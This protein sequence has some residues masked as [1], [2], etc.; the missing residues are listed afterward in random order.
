MDKI[1]K[2]NGVG[3]DLKRFYPRTMI[4]KIQLRDE[5]GYKKE[6]FII[7]NVA[8]INK[9]KN[10]IMLVKNLPKLREYIPNVKVLFIGKDNYQKV[11]IAVDQ[12]NLACFVEFLGYRNDVDKLIAI[13]DVAFSASLREGL[14]INIIESMAC[15]IPIVCSRNRGHNSLIKNDVSGLLFSVK[16]DEEMIKC[17]LSI[18]NSSSLAKKISV[19]VLNDS[20]QYD[21]NII[22]KRMEEIYC[23][24]M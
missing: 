16:N 17:I 15:G 5:L 19:N 1:Y 24:F 20:K 18:Y 23:K 12:L 9:N 22:V 6:D 13:S 8:E 2:I 10:Q 4:E 7:T 14:P 21:I 11:R 3:V